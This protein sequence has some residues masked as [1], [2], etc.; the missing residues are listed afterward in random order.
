MTY[1]LAVLL[2]LLILQAGFQAILSPNSLNML[3]GV[4]RLLMSVCGC[5][6][7]LVTALTSVVLHWTVCPVSGGGGEVVQSGSVLL[8]QYLLLMW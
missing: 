4:D 5:G 7:S 6:D 3:C 1:L 8:Q 2:D